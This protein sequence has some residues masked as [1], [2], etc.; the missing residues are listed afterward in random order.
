VIPPGR[1][2][3]FY[4]DDFSGST[5]VMEVLAINGLETVLFLD[6]SDEARLAQFQHCRAVGI[7]GKSRSQSPEWMTEH[8]PRIFGTLRRLGAPFCHYKVC[9]T[10]DSAPHVGSIGR[11][12]EI[13]QE[14]FRAPYVPVV[15]GAPALRR[16]CVFGNLFATVD[17]MPYRLDRHP[18]M[19]RHPL[20]PMTESDL[21][22]HLAKQTSKR[23]ALMDI[24]ALESADSAERLQ[25]L[26]SEKP[27]ILL[28]D[29]L[30]EPSLGEVGR[31][32]WTLRAEPQAFVVGSSGIEY[33]L[34]TYLRSA[35]ELPPPAEFPSA[36]SV[37]RLV[38]ISGSCSPVTESQIRWAMEHGFAA[39]GLDVAKLAVSD[40]VGELGMDVVQ[41]AL[42]E[43]QAGRSV[44]LYTA[45]GP[46]GTNLVPSDRRDSVF[47][48]RLGESLGTLLRALVQQAG[49]RRALIC[50]GDTSAHAGSQ[51]GIYALTTR[52]PLAP[53]SPMCVA[54][55]DDEHFDGLEI[56]FKGGQVGS[57][58]FFGLV[59]K[60]G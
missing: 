44:V 25:E 7:A 26:L 18:T 59:Q 20:T 60:G 15:V 19:S 3:S 39:V 16:Y 46:H 11:A 29:V 49:I 13:G 6:L 34:A 56:V 1:I 47:H 41:K 45:L 33:A 51:L 31:L 10:F 38:A 17:G 53:G 57:E 40:G 24:L 14:L 9:S 28:F 42:R 27:D 4:G 22:R 36:G 54:Y 8:L 48:Q 5:D 12:I 43:L 50:G 2:L 23:S 21:R 32:L 37:D 35:G 58:D 52:K 30:D 55:S